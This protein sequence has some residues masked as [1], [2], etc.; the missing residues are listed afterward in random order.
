MYYLALS[1]DQRTSSEVIISKYLLMRSILTPKQRSAGEKHTLVTHQ[2]HITAK[3]IM[4]NNPH[5]GSN[6]Q[7]K[8]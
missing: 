2:H 6:V 5:G 1:R 7:L 8:T 4:S 3:L